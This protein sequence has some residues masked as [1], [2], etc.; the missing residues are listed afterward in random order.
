MLV[1]FVESFESSYLAFPFIHFRD[2]RCVCVTSGPKTKRG[3]ILAAIT[4]NPSRNITKYIVDLL[5]KGEGKTLAQ[6]V[7]KSLWKRNNMILLFLFVCFLRQSK[8][9]MKQQESI[10]VR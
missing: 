8:G 5:N 10:S 7:I 1:L 3:L 6:E 2:V 9:C 4:E